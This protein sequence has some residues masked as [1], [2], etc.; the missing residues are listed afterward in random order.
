MMIQKHSILS[1]ALICAILSFSISCNPKPENNISAEVVDAPKGII[2]LNEASSI[3]DNYTKHRVSLI[4]PYETE[5][6][7]PE[8]A[9]EASRFVDFDYETMK[10]Y[11]AYVDQ[12]AAK[13]GVKKV[14][15]LRM[16]FANYPNKVDFPDGEK[17]VHPRQNSIFMVPTLNSN[18]NNFG[19][20]IG[21]DG[22]AALIKDRKS[23]GKDG[24]GY[25]ERSQKKSYAGFNITLN[26]SLQGGTSLTLNRGGD[27]P[28]PFGDF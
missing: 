14:T 9:F 6:R 27:G 20:Y 22:K 28:P 7:S 3:Y 15:K 11:I 8:V 25:L 4:E 24:M 13:A 2:S 23:S 26:S 17:I 1:V 19:F 16:Y 18:G 5:Q 10:N 12:E 21:S